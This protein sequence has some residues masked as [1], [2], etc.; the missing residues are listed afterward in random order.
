MATSYAKENFKI[1]DGALSVVAVNGCTTMDELPGYIP[2]ST[3][4]KVK[5]TTGKT[6]GISQTSAGYIKLIRG[7]T[8]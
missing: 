2:D 5:K 4:E 3:E 1:T 7:S 6:T 8:Y